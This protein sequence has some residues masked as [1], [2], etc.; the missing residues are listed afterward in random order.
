MQNIN[1][2]QKCHCVISGTFFYLGDL[3]KG[4]ISDGPNKGKIAAGTITYIDSAGHYVE[5]DKGRLELLQS[6]L[7]KV[8]LTN[9]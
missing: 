7:T 9:A 2:N 8:E 5:I 1:V 6:S 3:V 4:V